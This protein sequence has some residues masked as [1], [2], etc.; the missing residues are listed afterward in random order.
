[1]LDLCS[2]ELIGYAIAPG[3]ARDAGALLK[4]ADAAMYAGKEQGK[5]RLVRLAA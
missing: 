2:K 1:M 3:D 5:D 4:A